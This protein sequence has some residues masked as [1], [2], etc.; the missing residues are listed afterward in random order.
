TALV[1]EAVSVGDLVR[2]FEFQKGRSTMVELTYRR[3]AYAGRLV[4]DVP[5]PRDTT[6]VGIIRDGKPIAPTRDD[7]V[8][9]G[10][11][12]LLLTVPDVEDEL[13]LRRQLGGRAHR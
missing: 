12:L 10:D 5:L 2:L 9:A 3:G 4:D 8:E 11:E 7:P 1:E 6:L 13:D